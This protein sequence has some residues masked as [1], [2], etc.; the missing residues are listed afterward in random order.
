MTTVTVSI[1][2]HGCPFGIRR[3]VDSVL[4]QTHR[5]L[6]CVVT[7]DCDR[8]NPPWPRLQDIADPRLVRYDASANRGRYFADAV[9]LAATDAPWFTVHDA[10]DAAHPRWLELCLAE[11]EKST[12]DVVLT[13]QYVVTLRGNRVIEHP[14]ME[15]TGREMHHFGHMAGLWR[16]E[17]L[18][19]V[20]GPSPYY[21]VGYDSLLST[22]AWW[23]GRYSALP[24]P[25]YTRHRRRGSLT[26]SPKTGGK[27]A[28]RQQVRADLNNLWA[29]LR[30]LPTPERVGQHLRRQ[31]PEVWAV[32]DRDALRLRK[33]LGQ[34]EDR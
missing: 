26:T 11:A 4:A 16:T 5:D 8:I 28:Y 17:W 29:H 12:A 1:P 10:D 23:F 22:I 33:L 13:S 31:Y 27:S 2:Y 34:R 30:D 19:S 9:V 25:M 32:V 3:A 18:K 14:R 20:G 7:N 15:V 21:R 24:A 6:V